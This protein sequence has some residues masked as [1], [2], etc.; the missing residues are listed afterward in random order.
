MDHDVI[1]VGGGPAGLSAATQLA[2][3]GRRVLLLYKDSV[4]GQLS[5]V[6][7]INGYPGPGEKTGGPAMAAELAGEAQK[8][9]VGLEQAEVVEIEP[10]SS[11]QSVTCSDGRTYTAALV[12]VATGLRE[13]K[14]DVPGEDE[15]EGKGVIHCAMCDASL[16]GDR[17]VAVC[18][19]GRSGVLEAMFLA[20]YASKVYLIEAADSMSARAPLQ[21]R[22]RANPKIEILLGQRAVGIVGGDLVQGVQIVDTKTGEA[23]TLAVDGVLARVGWRPASEWLAPVLSL[24]ERGSVVVDQAMSTSASGVLAAGDVRAGSTLNASAAIADGRA[25]AE[26]AQRK[27]QALDAA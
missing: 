2:Q 19:S 15:Y 25:A 8:A 6:E 16:Y 5:T 24:D 11:C 9:G 12:I 1:V 18:G 3:A 13:R 21:E 22:A 26:E 27:L 4:G 14:L 20:R 10:Y 7:W 17:A 23:R